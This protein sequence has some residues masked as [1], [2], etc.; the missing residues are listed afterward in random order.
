MYLHV[1]GL[2]VYSTTCL[3]PA[4]TRHNAS[5]TGNTT[6]PSTLSSL[7]IELSAL[8]SAALRT[9][10]RERN[11]PASSN[12]AALIERLEQSTS[13]DDPGTQCEQPT[14][15]SHTK[16]TCQPQLSRHTPRALSLSTAQTPQVQVVVTH[17][18][19]PLQ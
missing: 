10:L 15:S 17:V 18:P 9:R 16:P 5:D 12:K 3:T 19:P 1:I 6:T 8:T 7:M 13:P 14:D 2:I 11:L 4:A